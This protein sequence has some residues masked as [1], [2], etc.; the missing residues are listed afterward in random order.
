MRSPLEPSKQRAHWEAFKAGEVQTRREARTKKQGRGER[1][2]L[3]QVKASLRAASSLVKR[4][5][6]MP[7]NAIAAQSAEHTALLE[8]SEAL[9]QQIERI[10]RIKAAEGENDN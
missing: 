7:D 5:E 4:P 9:Q 6:E 2:S 1:T 10:T 8:T 3:Q